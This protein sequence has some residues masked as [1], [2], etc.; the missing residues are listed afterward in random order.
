MERPQGIRIA[1]VALISKETLGKT[2]PATPILPATN[3]LLLKLTSP[4]IKVKSPETSKLCKYLLPAPSSINPIVSIAT[5]LLSVTCNLPSLVID[6]EPTSLVP[7][8]KWIV[9]WSTYKSFV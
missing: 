2:A 5:L 7:F 9:L 8:W 6:I 4:S 1:S 3:N